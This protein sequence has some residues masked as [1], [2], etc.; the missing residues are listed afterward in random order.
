MYKKGGENG[1]KMAV[2]CCINYKRYRSVEIILKNV[3]HLAKRSKQATLHV[4]LSDMVD[5][6]YLQFKFHQ[7]DHSVSSLVLVAIN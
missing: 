1:R 5:L 3:F 4:A 7:I 6:Y 2:F